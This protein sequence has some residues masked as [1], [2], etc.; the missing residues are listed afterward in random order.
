MSRKWI[1]IS[2]CLIYNIFRRYWPNNKLGSILHLKSMLDW[3]RKLLKA[4]FF[5]DLTALP[6]KKAWTSHW[7]ISELKLNQAILSN[8]RRAFGGCSNRT[9]DWRSNGFNFR[10]I[11]TENIVLTSWFPF[12]LGKKKLMAS[13]EDP[14]IIDYVM[15]K[16]KNQ[17]AEIW[18]KEWT[19]KL[20]IAQQENLM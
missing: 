17:R 8:E 3:K 5:V 12:H 13:Y 9:W 2:F 4:R 14:K 20:P 19:R 7:T 1:V 15:Q 10:H 11:S 6:W 16:D 18:I